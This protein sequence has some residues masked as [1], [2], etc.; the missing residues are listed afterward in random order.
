M[1][2]TDSARP[3]R[4][5]E[6]QQTGSPVFAVPYDANGNVLAL[7]GKSFKYNFKNQLEQVTLANGLVIRYEYDFRGNLTRR[8]ETKQGT[9]NET[10]YLSK[11]VEIRNGQTVRFVALN[12]VRVAI[13]LNGGQTR[14]IHSDQT[15]NARFFTDENTVKIA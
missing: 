7:A 2:Y 3:D 6:I 11:L 9:T 8:T 1:R 4:M 10:V 14:W 12:R 15:G 13:V 5:T